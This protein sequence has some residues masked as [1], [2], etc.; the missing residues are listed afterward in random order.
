MDRTIAKRAK[1]ASNLA[2]G[3]APYIFAREELK[4]RNGMQKWVQILTASA[5]GTY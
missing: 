1:N 5:H 2:N 4:Y 3:K